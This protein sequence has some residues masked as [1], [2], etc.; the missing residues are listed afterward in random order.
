MTKVCVTLKDLCPRLPISTRYRTFGRTATIG[1]DELTV[2]L[3]R[4]AGSPFK[5]D[6]SGSRE[7]V[8]LNPQFHPPV[9]SGWTDSVGLEFANLFLSIAP[10]YRKVPS[11][12]V[13]LLRPLP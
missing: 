1:L 7:V 9:D 5:I 4:G 10:V 12:A 2:W 11:D 6:G 8:E 3:T 13:V